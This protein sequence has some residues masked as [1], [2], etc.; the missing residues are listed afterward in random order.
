MAKRT[1]LHVGTTKSGTT[2]LQYV[3]WRSAR[4]VMRRHGVLLPGART[5]HFLAA[6]GVTERID[7]QQK[8]DMDPAVA[9][10]RLVDEVNAW[11]GDALI[12]HEL[13]GPASTNQAERAKSLLE[14]TEIHLVLTARSLAKQVPA[15]WQQQV[16]GGM[17]TPYGAFIRELRD[18]D[19]RRGRRARSGK[20]DWFWLVQDLT[21][22]ARRWGTHVSPDHVHVVTVPPSASDPTLLWRRYASVIGM[23]QADIDSSA[24]P[25]RNV[26]LGRVETEL[27]RQIHEVGDPRFRGLGRQRWTR[28]VLAST[29]LAQRSGR[30]IGLPQ[31]SRSWVAERTDEMARSLERSGFD[32]I[33]DLG[34][35]RAGTS[36]APGVDQPPTAE[37]VAKALDWTIERLTAHLHE[38]LDDHPGADISEPAVDP[39]D[40][41]RAVFELLEHIRAV[42]TG[43][44]PRPGH[45][46]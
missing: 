2:Y 23:D 31:E 7:Q 11:D 24:A 42:S 9:W 20:G 30:P 27:L 18:S 35:L 44:R 29:I 14:G 16:K 22:I 26:S 36:L 33:G 3:L 13:F 38:L 6:K 37:E 39:G 1:F 41:V 4:P 28:G 21:D 15:A 32:V 5:T 43:Q 46:P 45:A 10:P 8:S 17:T 40:G 25:M 12:A 34:D 19:C